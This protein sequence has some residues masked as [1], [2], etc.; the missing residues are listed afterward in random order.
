MIRV[1]CALLSLLAT[2]VGRGRRAGQ[3]RGQTAAEYMGIVVIVAIIIVAIATSNIG[4]TIAT[5]ITNKINDIF[6]AGG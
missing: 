5:N 2:T 4:Q 3:D 6:N 1:Y